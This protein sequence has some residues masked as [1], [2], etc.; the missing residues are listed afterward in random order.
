MKWAIGIGAALVVAGAAFW[1]LRDE[2][3]DGRTYRLVEVERRDLEAVVSATGTLEAVTTVQVGTQ[4]SGIIES[5]F[6]DFNDQVKQGQVIARIDTTLLANAVR[7]ADASLER[8]QAELRQAEREHT[9]IAR[10]HG[11]GLSAE[12]DLNQAEYTLD[13]ARAGIKSARAARARAVQNLEYA[14]IRAPVSGTVVERNVEVGQTVA[15]S[16]SAPQLFLIAEDLSRMQILASVD[17]S[18]IGR[19]R[20]GQAVR[21]SVQAWPDETFGGTVRQVRIQSTVTENVVNYSV[22]IDVSNDDRRLL[23]GM[24]ATVDFLLETAH[25][26]LAVPNAALRFRATPEMLDAMRTRMESERGSL[27]DS[28]RARMAEG[29]GADEAR[30]GGGTSG[31]G[32]FRGGSGNATL[33]WY[34]DADGRPAATR[35]RTGITDGQYT[36]IEGRNVTVGLSVIAG[37]LTDTP[38]SSSSPFG[39]G[40]AAQRP[41]PGGF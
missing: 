17:E 35:V 14:T 22:V 16:L 10:L 18:D 38:A 39:E 19:I 11:D 28:T 27:P 26:V 4:V 36:A 37:I 25:D 30:P 8:A 40:Q 23:P 33:L 2:P 31:S 12:T 3:A 6:A 15:A 9:R 5:I 34:L 1:L 21:F 13:L 20:D 7:E 24:T 41:R 32:S 29:G